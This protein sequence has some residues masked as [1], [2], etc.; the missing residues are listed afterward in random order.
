M[1]NK[2][3]KKVQE[4]LAQCQVL[5][6]SSGLAEIVPGYIERQESGIAILKT[7]DEKDVAI[8]LDKSG[9]FYEGQPL[10]FLQRGDLFTLYPVKP[11]DPANYPSPE[12]IRQLTCSMFSLQLSETVIDEPPSGRILTIIFGILALLGI[13]ASVVMLIL[14]LTGGDSGIEVPV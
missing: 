4:D 3:K 12:V 9:F 8:S 1:K 5:R 7:E 2:Q 10:F 14:L 13:V 6:I 11:L